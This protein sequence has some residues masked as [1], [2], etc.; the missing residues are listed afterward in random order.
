MTVIFFIHIV[1]FHKDTWLQSPSP[2]S[3]ATIYS[4]HYI[5]CENVVVILLMTL[6]NI[7]CI[8]QQEGNSNI[9][10]I[11]RAGKPRSAHP[12][13]ISQNALQLDY[14]SRCKPSVPSAF[15]AS[16]S[17][18]ITGKEMAWHSET[19]NPPPPSH[20]H[21]CSKNVLIVHL[22]R[23]PT[24]PY[25]HEHFCSKNVLIAHLPRHPTP[26]TGMSTFVA[27]MCS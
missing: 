20:E 15:S 8:S 1:D 19:P 27:R 22:P 2:L 23:H 16:V 18:L 17:R 25:R 3:S 6:L 7:D 11:P 9:D 13:N 10:C 26:P 21:F 24:P 14:I 4:F 5:S 12:Q